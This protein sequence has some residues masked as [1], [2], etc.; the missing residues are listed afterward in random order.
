MHVSRFAS[1]NQC[2]RR[3]TASSAGASAIRAKA[4]ANVVRWPPWAAASRNASTPSAVGVC[5]TR[6]ATAA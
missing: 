5:D 6:R 1:F 4:L 2:V 3:S